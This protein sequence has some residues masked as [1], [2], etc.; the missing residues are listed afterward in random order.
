MYDGS[1]PRLSG[2]APGGVANARLTRAT[3]DFRFENGRLPRLPFT[4]R[5]ALAITALAPATSTAA[6]DFRANLD[7]ALAPEL[8]SY[9]YVHFAAH[10]LLN[11]VRP[12]LSGVVLS[13]VDQ[14]GQPRSGLLTAPDVSSLRLGAELVVL[15]SCRSAE[16]REVRGEGLVGLTRAFMYAGAPRVVAS[17]W[18]VDD[19]ASSELMT[20]M[21][22]G[23][24]GPGRVSPT[25]ALRAAQLEILRHR[26]WRAPYYWAGFQLQGEWR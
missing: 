17:L 11:D 8:A 2:S 26:K 7:T 13:L 10:G 5:E 14:K 19:V 25:A 16:G 24:L 21:Y 3:R 6:L 4:R 12:E 18:P 15:S 20:R 22:R 23:M 9:R 1:D